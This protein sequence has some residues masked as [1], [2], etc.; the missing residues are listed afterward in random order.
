MRVRS[1]AV[2]YVKYQQELGHKLNT[3]INDWFEDCGNKSYDVIK[4]KYLKENQ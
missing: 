1:G 3:T 2:G 4:A